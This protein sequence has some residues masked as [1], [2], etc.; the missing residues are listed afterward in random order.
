MS[1]PIIF[2]KG[3]IT[4]YQNFWSVTGHSV[5]IQVVIIS[6]EGKVI[7]ILKPQEGEGDLPKVV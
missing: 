5:S 6:V 4:A 1:F 7:I 3:Y 2:I